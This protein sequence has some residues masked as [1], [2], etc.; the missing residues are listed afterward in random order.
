MEKGGVRQRRTQVRG[1]G[2][3]EAPCLRPASPTSSPAEPPDPCA[4]WTTTTET[5]APRTATSTCISTSDATTSDC[6]SAP[7]I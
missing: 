5:A 4:Q 3:L 6:Y 7:P 2:A 1:A